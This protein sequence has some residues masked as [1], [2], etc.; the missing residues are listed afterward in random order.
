M[1]HSSNLSTFTVSLAIEAHLQAEQFRQQHSHPHKAKQVYLNTLAIYAANFYLNC[2]DIETDVAAS[3]SWDPVQQ[4]LMDTADL[5]VKHCGKL[6]CR[7][8]LPNANEMIVPPEAHQ[9]RIGYVAV[10]LS[11]DLR[12]ATLI[13]YVE[14][15][16]ANTIPLSA[17]QP[18]ETLGPALVA[19]MTQEQT[20]P[21][22]VRLSQWFQN[23]SEAGWQAID[24]FWDSTSGGA[25]GGGPLA[26]GF[27]SP[28][29]A[30]EETVPAVQRRKQFQLEHNAEKIQVSMLLGLRPLAED[31]VEIWVRLCPT[32]AQQCLPESL[33]LRVLDQAERD[34]MQAEAR[35]TEAIQLK[36]TGT[37]EE[38]F[39]I[40][41]VWH[42]TRI[43]ESFVL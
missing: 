16:E 43:T 15:I 24:S 29:A 30:T 2:L 5:V 35:G 14:A 18:I 33:K 11:G 1:I 3:D 27:R 32:Q 13:G 28:Q 6:V 8:V 34:V 25:S 17:L 42:E 21:A 41:V 23:W 31:T 39:S 22:T 37:T 4:T 10:R 19:L 12:Q 20:Q 9:D 40:E 36:F 26:W 7:P 38:K